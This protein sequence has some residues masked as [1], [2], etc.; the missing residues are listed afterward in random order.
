MTRTNVGIGEMAVSKNP[1]HHLK[2]FRSGSCVAII[3]LD[4]KVKAVGLVHTALPNS[5]IN[6]EKAIKLKDY[7]ADTGIPKLTH[8]MAKLGCHPKGLGL[9]IKNNW[10]CPGN[11]PEPKI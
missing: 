10:W 1:D 11:G 5:S 2:T 3:A 6:P 8:E 9:I 7:F 4:P